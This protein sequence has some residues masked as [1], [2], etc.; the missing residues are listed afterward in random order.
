MVSNSGARG[1]PYTVLGK[2]Y[3]PLL[4]SDGF[5]ESG[6]AS[7]YGPTFHGKKTS[8]GEIYNM[9]A[10]TAAHKLLPLGSTVRVTHLGNGRNIIVRVNDRGPFVGTRIIDLSYSAAKQLDMI[11]T[12]TARVRID[13]LKA[14]TTPSTPSIGNVY[15]QL[16][17]VS[18]NSAATALVHDLQSEGFGGRSLFAPAQNVWRVQ[19]GP[20]ST[21]A[22]AEDIAKAK[23][24]SRF[25]GAYIFS[26]F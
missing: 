12:G 7:W 1:K 19:A 11:G 10:M 4:S 3:Y 16:I 26:D 8:N 5:H 20:F 2:T 22:Q 23:L 13:A 21:R 6:V 18:N 17:A 15:I 24:A 14:A 25:P 9:Y